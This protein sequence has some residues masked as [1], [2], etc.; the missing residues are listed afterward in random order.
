MNITKNIL[1]V[2]NL[3]TTFRTRQGLIKAVDNV[4]FD[5]KERSTLGI[6]GESG[7]GKSVTALSIMRLIPKNHGKIT[8]GEII[9]DGKNICQLSSGHMRTIRGNRISM[10]FQEPMTSLNPVFTIG[11][12]IQE[13]LLLH[14]HLTPQKAKEKTIELLQLVGIPSPEKRIK[15]YPHHLSGGMRQRVMIAIA[16]ACKPDILIADEP[17]T[18]LDVTIQAQI[19]DLLKKLQ[20][21]LDMSIIMITH[22]LGVVAEFCDDILVMYCGKIVEKANVDQLFATP[23]HPYTKG[24]IQSIPTFDIYKKGEQRLKTI[25]GTLPSFH[26][27]PLGCSFQ[28]RCQYAQ[29]ACRG[30]QGNPELQ[31]VASEHWSACFFPLHPQKH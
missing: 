12:Q 1:S 31:K 14:Q 15:N 11:A 3:V 16:L 24:L 17:T 30:V 20:K 10:I 29:D 2:K 18:A 25:K 19:L 5:L 6:V 22:D 7:S 8:Q 28:D 27:I 26:N 21:E 13:S 23:Q 4:S 9:F